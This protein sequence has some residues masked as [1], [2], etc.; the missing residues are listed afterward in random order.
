MAGLCEGGNESLGS[1]KTICA[2]C[3][4]EQRSWLKIQSA[5]GHTARQCHD[6]LVEACGETAL[7][8]RTVARWVRAFNEGRVENM[9]R[10]GRPSVSEEDVQA[11][12]ALLD[13]DRR[14]TMKEPPRDVRLRTVSDILQAVGRPSETS[15]E[16]EMLQGY[17][18]FHVAG[19]E[20]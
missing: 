14:Q 13:N 2:Y 8:Y 15:T 3:R 9:A 16:Q 18:D 20:L 17:Y 1:L 10:P 7:S 19:N 11:V 4:Q 6:G 5:R 12:S